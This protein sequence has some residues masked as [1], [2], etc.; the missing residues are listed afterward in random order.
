MSDTIAAISTVTAPAGIGIIRIS[1]PE[2][3]EVA[4]KIFKGKDVKSL[5][6]N[7]INHGWIEFNGG[8]IDEVLLSVFKEPHSYTGEDTVEINCH[9]GIIAV[10]N[11]LD[12]VLASGAKPA[13]PGEF[14]KR[15][16]LNGRMDLSEAEAVMD[17]I[18]A[19]SEYALQSAVSQL[20]GSLNDKISKI[21]GALLYEL[22]YIESAL[23]DP[24]HISLDGYSEKLSGV[25]KCEIEKLCKLSR[26]SEKGKYIEEGIKT[27]ILGRPNVG[28]SSLLNM[29]TGKE[30]AI[31]TDI[32]GTT[33]D[34]LEETVSLGKVALKIL[35][36]AGIHDAADKVEQIGIRLAW[37]KAD[38]ADLILYVIDSSEDIE[39]KDIEIL[40]KLSG[41]KGILLLNKTDLGMKITKE[42]VGKI[43]DFPIIEI[44]A[45]EGIGEEEIQ[46][47]IEEMFFNGELS[48][49]D[50]VFITNVRHKNLI[51]SAIESLKLVENSINEGLPEDFYSIDLSGAINDLDAII[52]GNLSE[53]LVDEI[54]SKFCM[55]K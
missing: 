24:E 27:V 38:E 6:A 11:I 18:S 14:T 8:I 50:E 25:V 1:G 20:K 22:A 42:D 46:A 16:F 44:S 41:K 51:D 49:N 28:K 9:G 48:F 40:D 21:R 26:T 30:R 10:K 36:T 43:T 35:D 23:D 3:F 47:L 31:V 4:G 39:D 32:P 29:M 37:E 33:R 5:A 34:V 7:T 19:K 53:D 52:G 15:A 55:G 2:A 17:V 45:K 12:A 54:F 13:E